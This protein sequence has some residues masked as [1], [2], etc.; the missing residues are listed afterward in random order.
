MSPLTTVL[1][2]DAPTQAEPALVSTRS[3]LCA[4]V[5]A[6][7]EDRVWRVSLRLAGGVARRTPAAAA[8]AARMAKDARGGSEVQIPAGYSV[9][10]VTDDAGLRALEPKWRELESRTRSYGPFSSWTWLGGWWAEIGRSVGYTPQIFTIFQGDTLVGVAPFYLDEDRFGAHLLRNLGDT[11]V[12]SEYLDV[13]HDPVHVQAVA[14]A[15][16]ASLRDLGNVDAIMLYDLDGSSA[17]VQRLTH[18]HAGLIAL[19][20]E[21]HERMPCVRLEGGYENYRSQLSKN[22]RYNLKRKEK[23]LTK[24][25]PEWRFRV[26]EDPSEVQDALSELFRL[27][28]LRWASKGKPGNFSRAEVQ[29]FHRRVAPQ[30]LREGVL[31]LYVL[32]VAP[33]EVAAMLYCLR[34]H[35]REFYLQAGLDP[36]YQKIA[37]GFCLMKLVIERAAADGVLEF[38]MLRGTESYKRHW[39]NAEHTTMRVSCARP[40][41]KGVLWATRRRLR[42]QL[43]RIV[44]AEVPDT[45]LEDFRTWQTK[46]GQPESP[47]APTNA[48]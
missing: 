11:L 19:E 15:L 31:R 26:I 36:A 16:L 33:N 14:D 48:P 20:L 29:A 27:H 35:D 13:I 3:S 25:H 12:G 4:L 34:H 2:H 8:Y 9:A 18:S 5:G 7:S 47:A 38:D 22:M 1:I 17:V 10:V 30:L 28:R 41:S 46:L 43:V 45:M 42:E 37:A 24:V 44:K 21:G 32:E 40:T 6:V 39:T 23:K